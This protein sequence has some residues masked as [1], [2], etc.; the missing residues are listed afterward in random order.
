MTRA[1]DLANEWYQPRGYIGQ[2]S[3]T[4]GY[5]QTTSTAYSTP[6]DITGLSVTFTAVAN[7][8]YRIT[9]NIMLSRP[10]GA[11]VTAAIRNGSTILAAS[12]LDSA[13]TGT[14][15][16]PTTLVYIGSFSAGSVTVKGSFGTSGGVGTVQV[17]NSTGSPI[18]NLIVEDV[19]GI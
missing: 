8:Q 18:P 6:T 10:S 9:M 14:I 2:T 1:R 4:A 16:T 12:T 3:L 15:T 5:T 19:G 17:G 7:R 11:A 13:Y